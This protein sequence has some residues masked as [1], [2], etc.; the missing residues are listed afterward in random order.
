MLPLSEN[1][2][3]FL[4][5][6]YISRVKESIMQGHPLPQANYRYQAEVWDVIYAS[7]KQA[8]VRSFLY[9]TPRL[10]SLNNSQKNTY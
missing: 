2:T 3:Q 5:L 6:E 4:T 9:H 10:M 8:Y 1:M 7:D